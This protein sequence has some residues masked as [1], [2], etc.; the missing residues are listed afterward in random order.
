MAKVTRQ[1]RLDPQLEIDMQKIC[2][3]EER[4]FSSMCNLFLKKAAADY[5]SEHPDIVQK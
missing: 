3:N 2:E 5:L 4:S 1:I